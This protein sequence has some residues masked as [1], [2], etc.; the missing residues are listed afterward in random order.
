MTAKEQP[1]WSSS[2]SREEEHRYFLYGHF[3][4]GHRGELGQRSYGSTV[5]SGKVGVET[6]RDVWS[7]KVSAGGSVPGHSNQEGGES[8]EDRKG[9]KEGRETGISHLFGE[10]KCNFKR[11]GTVA[12]GPQ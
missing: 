1:Q 6:K 9:G 7:P 10:R 2:S 5:F 8:G 3:L 4:Y 11:G 12:F